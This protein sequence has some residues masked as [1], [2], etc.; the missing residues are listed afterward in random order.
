MPI[1]P[2]KQQAVKLNNDQAYSNVF[3]SPGKERLILFSTPTKTEKKL[4]S[5]ISK[6][7]PIKLKSRYLTP[8][9]LHKLR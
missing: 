6:R 4:V 3:S 7:V 8:G 5:L 9:S 1:G 2:N